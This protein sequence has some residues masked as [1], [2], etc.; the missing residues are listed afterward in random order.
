MTYVVP[1]G[2]DQDHGDVERLVEL[3]EAADLLEAVAVAEEGVGVGAELRGNVAAIRDS[4]EA[5]GGDLDLLAVLDEEL[6][7]L[8][9]GELSDDTVVERSENCFVMPGQAYA[10]T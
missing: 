8:I 6:G 1:D 4:L 5:G 3:G 10:L 7:E 2:H 9:V